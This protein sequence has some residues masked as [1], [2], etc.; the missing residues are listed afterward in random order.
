MMPRQR[1][2]TQMHA[3]T[4]ALIRAAI[5]EDIGTGDVTSEFFIPA[6]S[7]SNANLVAREAGVMSGGEI[8]RAVFLEIDG[9]IDVRVLVA[10]GGPFEKG[11]RLMEISGGTRSVLSAERTAL[12]FRPRLCGV[13]TMTRRHVDAV[14]PHAVKVLDTR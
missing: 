4:L 12:N 2:R 14:K 5:A 11:D 3:S 7:R 9:T 6:D 13:A 10:D 8:A 1:P